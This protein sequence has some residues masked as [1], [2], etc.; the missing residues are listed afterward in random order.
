MANQEPAQTLD[1]Q[2]LI[3]PEP[4]MMLHRVL[5]KMSAGEI[6]E[7]IATDPATK[8]DIPNFCEFLP[9]ELVSE[10]TSALP[11]RYWIKKGER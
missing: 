7:V 8:R 11:L 6:V 3:C 2:G 1:T 5:R 9:H 4:V 10:Q